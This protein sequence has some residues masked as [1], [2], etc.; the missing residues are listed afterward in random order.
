MKFFL[1]VSSFYK[2]KFP[3]YFYADLV[4][5]MGKVNPQD[6]AKGYFYE[7]TGLI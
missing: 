7:V 2:F 4:Q 6:F 1:L 3:S 5:F